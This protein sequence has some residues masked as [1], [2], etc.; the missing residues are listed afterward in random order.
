MYLISTARKKN[1][2]DAVVQSTK[3]L[4]PDSR[5]WR[6]LHSSTGVG[7]VPTN[8]GVLDLRYTWTMD[9]RLARLQA[10]FQGVYNR[11]GLRRCE[12]E[13]LLFPATPCRGVVQNKTV[14]VRAG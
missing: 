11:L 4:I 6:C 12:D 3:F 5:R 14:V 13:G 10:F 7:A 2:L 9:R 8:R 1:L